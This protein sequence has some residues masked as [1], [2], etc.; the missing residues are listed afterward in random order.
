MLICGLALVKLQESVLKH[1]VRTCSWPSWVFA[2]VQA[3][4]SCSEQELLLLFVAVCG[5][6]TVVASLVA[7][8]GL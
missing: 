5:L 7:E 3:V 6:P 1:C 4:S 2:A 8:R